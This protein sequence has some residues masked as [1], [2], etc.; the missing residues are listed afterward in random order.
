MTRADLLSSRNY[1]IAKTQLDLH[2]ELEAFMAEHNINRT[3]LAE[4]LGVTKGYVSQVLNGDFDHKV[5]KLV[6][7]ALLMGKVPSIK[8]IDLA[9]YVENDQRD[10]ISVTLMQE[11][12]GR[13]TVRDISP[14]KELGYRFSYEQE[15]AL[16][17]GSFCTHKSTLNG[18]FECV[19]RPVAV[20]TDLICC[21]S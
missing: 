6:D 2:H 4:R 21:S 20:E 12:F 17:H 1:W 5:S 19:N 15:G 14:A 13:Q 10:Y 11:A 8:Y 7:L 16:L 18:H 3:Q 9:K